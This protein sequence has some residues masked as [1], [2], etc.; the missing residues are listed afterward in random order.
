M[1]HWA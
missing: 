1:L